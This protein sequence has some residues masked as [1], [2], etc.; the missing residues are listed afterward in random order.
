VQLVKRVQ[1]LCVVYNTFSSTK[2][3]YRAYYRVLQKCFWGPGIVCNAESVSVTV[4]HVWLGLAIANIYV[5]DMS[6]ILPNHSPNL[7]PRWCISG[8]HVRF[9]VFLMFITYV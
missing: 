1:L 9:Y 5:P 2:L 7:S 6:L 4:S 3:Q 8:E